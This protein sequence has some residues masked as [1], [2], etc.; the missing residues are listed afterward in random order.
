MNWSFGKSFL[1]T[2]SKMEAIQVTSCQYGCV[3]QRI[4]SAETTELRYDTIAESNVDGNAEY[5]ALSSTRSQKKKLKQT[6]ASVP[7]IQYRLR[8]A[9]TVWKE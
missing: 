9:K 1:Q 6:N 7:L 8:S 5:T 2:A 4:K 3:G